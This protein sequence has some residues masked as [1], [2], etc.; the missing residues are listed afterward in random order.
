[1]SNPGF[2]LDHVFVMSSVGAPEGEELLRAGVPEGPP[3]T[4]PGQGTA[5]RRFVLGNAYIELLWVRDENE[6]RSEDVRRTGLWERW[7]GRFG[8][9][10]PFGVVLRP[11]GEDQSP[12]FDTWEYRPSYLPS[13]LAI[14]VARGTP[15]TEPAF[16]YL[17]FVR[18]GGRFGATD[19]PADERT[20]AIAHVTMSGPRRAT[21]GPALA[22]AAGGWLTFEGSGHAH[23]M[24]LVLDG[25]RREDLVDLRPGL[26]A[27]LQ[28]NRASPA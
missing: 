18:R 4:H 24:T 12:P 6:A 3:N 15:L 26:P 27:V 5:C 19:K 10:C 16:F 25:G 21:S 20:P 14:H 22:V 8:D 9:A 2:E 1:M 7:A 17:P 11:S 13:P 28:W 23:T